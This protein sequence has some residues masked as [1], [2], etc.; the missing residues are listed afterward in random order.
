LEREV[1]IVKQ[2]VANQKGI[3]VALEDK[4]RH[5]LHTVSSLHTLA[6]FA[7][8]VVAHKCSGL[9]NQLKT[10]SMQFLLVFEKIKEEKDALAAANVR[11][12]EEMAEKE[13]E[14]R[15][16]LARLARDCE[17]KLRLAREEG[18]LSTTIAYSISTHSSFPTL[19]CTT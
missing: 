16:G 5:E 13:R 12:R 17:E 18:S 14:H 7:H 10:K 15:E 8:P 4:A 2:E 19:A 1:T 9:S 6:C 3:I 11:L